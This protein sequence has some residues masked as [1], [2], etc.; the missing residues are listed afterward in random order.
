MAKMLNFTL[1][2][3]ILDHSE[4]NGKFANEIKTFLTD[5]LIPNQN[6]YESYIFVATRACL[7]L[8][9]NIPFRSHHSLF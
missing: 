7:V 9:H 3:N 6:D 4:N 1:I 2:N 8:Y 5:S